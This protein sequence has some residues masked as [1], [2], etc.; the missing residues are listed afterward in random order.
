M[1]FSASQ[2][3]YLALTNRMSDIEFQGQQ[4]NQQR[5]TL[6]NASSTE[7]GKLQDM[8]VPVP[9]SVL[10]F[11]K[12]QYS[13]QWGTEP[14]TLGNVRPSESHP[15]RYS[16]DI[17]RTRVG[18][19]LRDDG[20]VRIVH[21]TNHPSNSQYSGLMTTDGYAIRN[22]SGSDVIGSYNSSTQQYENG[23]LSDNQINNLIQGFRNA[24]PEYNNTEEYPDQAIMDLMC[25]SFK[26][27]THGLAGGYTLYS[28]DQID[29]PGGTNPEDPN[30]DPNAFAYVT[31]YV[32]DSNSTYTQTTVEDPCDLV[33]NADGR[34]ASI[35]IETTNGRVRTY[36]LE[37][38]EIT[39]NDAYE[40]AFNDYEYQ[41]Y[42]YDKTQQDINNKMK[43][44]EDQDK[45]LQLKLTR[46]DNERNAVNTEMEAVKK[47]IQDNIDKSFKSFGG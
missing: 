2:A 23:I 5:T 9:P 36:Q 47:V 12:I 27:E 21:D 41:K 7:Y 10:D 17:N 44:I 16:V 42:Q 33:F 18:N 40:K 1:G 31:C 38:S 35:G 26:D 22:F 13:F 4:I 8:V 6:S 43:I 28:R 46:L 32:N 19:C 45:K 14:A 20:Q 24:F 34:I 11:K 39:D 29:I 3:R 25:I 15:G 30:Y 37:A